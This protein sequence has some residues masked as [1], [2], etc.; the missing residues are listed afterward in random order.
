MPMP[1]QKNLALFPSVTS[2]GLGDQLQQQRED[3]TEEQKKQRL[4][5][6]Q[7]QAAI[8]PSVMSVYGAAGVGR[9]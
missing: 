9:G 8:N 4:L 3:E 7:M 6:Q 1:N 2:I 5:N